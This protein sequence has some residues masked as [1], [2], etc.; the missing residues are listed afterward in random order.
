MR[1]SVEKTDPGYC[2]NGNNVRIFLD[3]VELKGVVIMADEEKGEILRY[4]RD[5][6][7]RVF[8]KGHVLATEFVRGKVEIVVPP[9]WQRIP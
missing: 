6:D 8:L 3:D 4:A 1:V 2:Q 9:G 5:E 7:G